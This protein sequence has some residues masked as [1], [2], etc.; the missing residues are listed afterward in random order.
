M[1]PEG[2][3]V[4]ARKPVGEAQASAFIAAAAE[5]EVRARTLESLTATR[6]GERGFG[7]IG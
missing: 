7:Q 6:N 4:A 1:L 5:R 3:M 2:T